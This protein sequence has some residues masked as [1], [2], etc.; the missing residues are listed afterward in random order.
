MGQRRAHRV[1]RRGLDA[2]LAAALA[3]CCAACRGVLDMP[4]DGPVCGA[5]WAN[6]RAQLL[7]HLILPFD[8]D[9]DA[10]RAASAY[11][12]AVRDI[13]HAFKYE[14]RR[15]LAA[16]LGG[17]MRE[18]GRDLLADAACVVPVPL[19]PW[20]RMRRGFNQASDLA[21]YLG[22]PIARVLWRARPTPKQMALNRAARRRNVRR[23]FRIAPWATRRMLDRDVRGRS[24]VLVDDVVTTGATLHACAAALRE[25]GAK[26]VRALTVAVTPKRSPR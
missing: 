19:H 8:P 16:P 9:I 21:A 20:R 11:D 22:A 13:I 23:A 3:P 15:S 18:A 10:G 2:L 7:P 6:A 24:V 12:G 4:L 25:A 17:W 14:G 5:C 26:E 1:C